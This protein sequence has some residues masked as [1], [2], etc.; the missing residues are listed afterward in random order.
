[1]SGLNKLFAQVTTRMKVSL[2][3]AWLQNLH[4]HVIC[5]HVSATDRMALVQKSLCMHTETTIECHC[6][7][8]GS[9]K[10]GAQKQLEWKYSLRMAWLPK[11]A[12]TGQPRHIGEPSGSSL[13][14]CVGAPA[15]AFVGAPT[16]SCLKPPCAQNNNR[17]KASFESGLTV[18]TCTHKYANMIWQLIEMVLAHV[19]VSVCLQQELKATVWLSGSISCVLK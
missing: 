19:H 8:S 15:P 2:R 6:W 4:I 3:M 5:K 16:P 7:L 17:M 9:K 11:L 10:Q 14:A 18:K 1:M 12:H 13:Q